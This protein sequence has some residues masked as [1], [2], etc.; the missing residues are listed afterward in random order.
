MNVDCIRFSLISSEVDI[1]ITEASYGAEI[2]VRFRVSVL[3]QIF[4]E[5]VQIRHQNRAS[6]VSVREYRLTGLLIAGFI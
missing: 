6:E 2:G 1:F 3:A 4:D 5:L